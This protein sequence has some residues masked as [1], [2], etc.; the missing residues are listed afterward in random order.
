M[1]TRVGGLDL[2]MLVTGKADFFAILCVKFSVSGSLMRVSVTYLQVVVH[3]SQA[4]VCI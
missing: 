3:V 2:N 4:D 1:I